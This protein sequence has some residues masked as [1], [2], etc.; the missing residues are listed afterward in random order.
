MSIPSPAIKLNER[1]ECKRDSAQRLRDERSECKR[2]SAQRLRDERSEC[3]RGSAQ[4]LKDELYSREATEAPIAFTQE[5][6]NGF[7][8]LRSAT[9]NSAK[10]TTDIKPTILMIPPLRPV[11]LPIY[12]SNADSEDAGIIAGVHGFGGF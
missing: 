6:L 12:R 10:P 4:P 5:C 8:D 11:C 3:K 7:R 9:S 2:D 1:S